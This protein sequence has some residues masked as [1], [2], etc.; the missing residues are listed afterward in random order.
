M[1]KYALKFD[2][3]RRKKRGTEREKERVKEKKTY[4]YTNIAKYTGI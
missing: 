4:L 1:G 3:W 2:T